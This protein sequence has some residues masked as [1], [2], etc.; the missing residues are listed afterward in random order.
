MAG[1]VSQACSVDCD[2]SQCG[3][4]RLSFYRATGWAGHVARVSTASLKLRSNGGDN[5]QHGKVWWREM[6]VVLQ[7][8]LLSI[9]SILSTLL[10]T[11]MDGFI[12]C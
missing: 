7:L 9:L 12:V 5:A 6:D 8:G 10:F 3:L 1:V 2:L 11:P 4:T